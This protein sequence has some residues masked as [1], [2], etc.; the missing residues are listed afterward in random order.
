MTAQAYSEWVARGRAHQSEQRPV[1]AMLCF[2][3]ALRENAGGADAHLHLG[4]VLWQMGRLNDA[5]QEWQEATR[6]G[7]RVLAAHLALAEGRLAV[8]D[9]PGAAEASARALTLFPD[10]APHMLVLGTARLAEAGTLDEGALATAREQIAM[11]LARDHGLLRVASLAGP[12]AATLDRLPASKGR[13]ALL[14]GIADL[15]QRGSIVAAAP[16]LLIALVVEWAADDPGRADILDEMLHHASQREYGSSEHEPLRRIAL[17]AQHGAHGAARALGERYATL[18]AEAFAS[19]VPLMWTRRTHG[20]ALRIVALIDAGDTG[21]P[22]WLVALAGEARDRFEVTLVTLEREVADDLPPTQHDALRTLTLSRWP[23][24]VDARRLAW[25]DADVLVDL[26]GLRA[27]SGPLLAARPARAIVTLADIEAPLL[28]P[29]VDHVLPVRAAL[30]AEL[31]RAHAR[32]ADVAG[33][34]LDA[35]TTAALFNEAV[36]LHQSGD[37]DEAL[38]RYDEVLQTQPGHAQTL[39][40]RGALRRDRKELEE[41]LADFSAALE[42]APRFLDAR[43]AAAQAALDAGL[44]RVA[45]TLAQQQLASA[46]GFTAVWRV[47]GLAHLALGEADAAVEV[48]E[49]ALQLDVTD[50]ETHYNHGVALQTL[51]RHG[52]AAR[53]YQRAL[54]FRPDFTAADF[55]LGVLFQEQGNTEAATAAYRQVLRADPRHVTAYKNLG[56][57]LFA[58][59]RLDEWRANFVRFEAQCPDALPLAVQALEVCQ[60]FADFERLEHYLD[61]LRNER[62]NARSPAELVE[63]LEELLYLLLFFDIEP[64]LLHRFST[65]YDATAKVVYGEPMTLPDGRDTERKAGRVRL[66]YL[67]ADLRNHVMGKMVWSAVQHHDRDRFELFFYALSAKEDEWTARFRGLADHFVSV[68]RLSEKEAAERIAQDRLD[69]LV[70]LSTHTRG[71]KPG[72]LARKPA[73]VQITHVASAGSVGLSAIDFKLTDHYA[74][75]P[76]NQEHMIERLLPMDGCVYPYRHIPAVAQEHHDRA[77]LGL[78]ADA[79]VIGAFVTPMKLS[80]RCLRVWSEVL[81]RLPQARLAISPNHPAWEASF[82]R[83]AASAGIPRERLV[84]IPQG[85]SENENQGRYALIDVV[86]DPMPFGGV[87]GTL[88]ALD[89]GVPVITLCGRRHGERTSY[90][91]LMNLGVPETIAT[92]GRDYVDLAVRLASDRA[93]A[94]DV[95]AKIRAGI[96]Q[97]PLT[98]MVRHTRALEAAYA[99]AM[100][101]A[102]SLLYGAPV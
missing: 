70:D 57:V 88:E 25:L 26:V 32:L 79:F 56:E 73:R 89:A 9:W 24:A 96:A 15:L 23:G 102:A 93:F 60:H 59:G 19:S 84:V 44:P 58:A 46:P 85:R 81:D 39:F 36:R 33:S 94:E 11:A 83:L 38:R 68:A 43:V 21:A 10:L 80:R 20:D 101:Q 13:A 31:E 6:A 72:I 77:R 90:S 45:R 3:R 48:F 65:T 42:A 95:R 99:E 76:A 50:G 78:A 61:G 54:A 92:T 97:S 63:S 55:N 100:A 17:V 29:L 40:L 98:D 14:A 67:S 12:L 51:R 4:E 2:R 18:C 30:V 49:H 35:A 91:I 66:G 1:D 71:A 82:V 47:L 53:A 74:D 7:P 87:N 5:V 52:D 86:L 41:A 62:F 69:I 64:D 16:A 22:Q 28:P 27:G 8:A 37:R 75:V 34:G